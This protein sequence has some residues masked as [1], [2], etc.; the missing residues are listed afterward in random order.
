MREFSDEKVVSFKK[1]WTIFA[2]YIL[3]DESLYIFL[4]VVPCAP[5]HIMLLSTIMMELELLISYFW[6]VFGWYVLVFTEPIQEE[7]S[8]GTFWYYYFGGNP[9][10]P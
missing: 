7:N 1:I 10:F 2:I 8:V 9:F 3:L 5:T 6:S 4:E